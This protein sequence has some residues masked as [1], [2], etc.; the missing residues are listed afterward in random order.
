MVS[1]KALFTA[2]MFGAVAVQA[3]PQPDTQ[4]NG[5]VEANQA[6]A[7]AVKAAVSTPTTS[8]QSPT[9]TSASAT[10]SS[11]AKSAAEEKENSGEEGEDE[12][13]DEDD[14]DEDDL[15]RR[16]YHPH[17]RNGRKGSDPKPH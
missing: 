10:P 14:E 8:I 6:A 5:V 12:D 16:S 17:H 7:S 15:V 3:L 13:E 1:C 2:L 4:G 9:P 11:T